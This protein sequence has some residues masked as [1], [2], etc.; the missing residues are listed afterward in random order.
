ML[1]EAVMNSPIPPQMKESLINEL[2]N[3]VEHID[4][5]TRKIYDPSAVWLESIQFADYVSQMAEHILSDCG[6]SDEQ[7]TQTLEHMLY[8][9]ETF[10]QVAE[11][12]MEILDQADKQIEKELN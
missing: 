6:C 8:I 4:E 3:L 5:A 12:S 9:A 1:A 2:P 10:K 7:R 11:N